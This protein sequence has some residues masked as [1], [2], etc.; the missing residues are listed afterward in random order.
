MAQFFEVHPDNPQARLLRQA[1]A[2]LA[3]GAVAAVQCDRG[4][5]LIGT[6]GEA[7]AAATVNMSV[8]ETGHHC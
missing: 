1:A 5:G 4:C 7:T 6:A 3:G 2:L 8:D